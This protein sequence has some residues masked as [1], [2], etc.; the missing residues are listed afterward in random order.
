MSAENA[1]TIELADADATH[2]LGHAVGEQLQAGHGVALVGDLGAGKTT[3]TRGIAVGLAVD[4]PGAV[5]SPTYLVIVEHPGRVPLVHI[6]AYLPEK[7]R[8][9]LLDG[10]VDYL[11]ELGGVVV[12]EWADRIEDLMPPDTVRIELRPSA[13]G[14]RRA[15]IFGG[16]KFTWVRELG[17]RLE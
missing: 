2:R 12:V 3:L 5:T 13:S 16:P 15:S 14:G 1:I 10:G 7:T 11:G 9:F 8:G 6:D 17:K 4:D